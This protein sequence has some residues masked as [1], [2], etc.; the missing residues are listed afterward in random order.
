MR[1]FAETALVP[2]RFDQAKL[3]RGYAQ[4]VRDLR[5]RDAERY[6]EELDEIAHDMIADAD[7]LVRLAEPTAE[8]VFGPAAVNPRKA[9]HSGPRRGS[10]AQPDF[11]PLHRSGPRSRA[12]IVLARAA[13]DVLAPG[14][15]SPAVGT[16]GPQRACRAGAG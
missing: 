3:L 7:S 6:L 2:R 1:S 9:A 10:L 15:S 4:R 14:S 11:F 8:S 16:V 13:T 12:G 5:F